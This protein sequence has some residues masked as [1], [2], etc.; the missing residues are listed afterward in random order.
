[1]TA[2]ISHLAQRKEQYWEMPAEVTKYCVANC[3]GCPL[4]WNMPYDQRKKRKEGYR[5]VLQSELP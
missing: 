4:E 3:V 5:D 2:L 1:M